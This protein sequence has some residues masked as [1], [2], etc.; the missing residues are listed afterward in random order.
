MP[1][2]SMKDIVMEHILNG[3]G[4]FGARKIS[5]FFLDAQTDTCQ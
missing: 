4:L 2:V 3:F 1:T 5:E